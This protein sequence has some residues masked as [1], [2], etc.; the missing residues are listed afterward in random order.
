M[1]VTYVQEVLVCNVNHKGGTNKQDFFCLWFFL[2]LQMDII[3]R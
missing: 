2:G 3:A 1:C